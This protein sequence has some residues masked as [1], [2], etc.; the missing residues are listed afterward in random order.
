MSLVLNAYASSEGSGEPVRPH[1][2]VITFAARAYIVKKQMNAQVISRHQAKIDSSAC[3]FLKLDYAFIDSDKYQT[4]I[5]IEM[6]CPYF[7][8]GY[9]VKKVTMTICTML[10]AG[11]YTKNLHK[12]CM[13][14]Y[15][16]KVFGKMK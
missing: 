8:Y 6:T 11:K 4:N 15:Q 14:T 12:A 5:I 2:L 10:T 1:S 13:T 7:L 9:V 16:K 3:T